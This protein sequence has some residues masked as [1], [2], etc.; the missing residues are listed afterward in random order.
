M[1]PI[2]RPLD[3]IFPQFRSLATKLLNLGLLTQHMLDLG[4]AASLERAF[5]PGQFLLVNNG[6][7]CDICARRPV[8]EAFSKLAQS[9]S[10]VGHTV[11]SAHER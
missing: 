4:M 7:G 5:G 2:A 3:F 9:L 11:Q 8:G 10:G 1:R 6:I